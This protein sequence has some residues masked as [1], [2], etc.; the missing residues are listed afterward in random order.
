MRG[1]GIKINAIYPNPAHDE[2]ELDLH[3]SLKQDA[4]V[5]IFDA[6]GRNVLSTSVDEPS[7]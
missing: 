7:D 2:I 5:E 6:L 3:S 1:N 4:V